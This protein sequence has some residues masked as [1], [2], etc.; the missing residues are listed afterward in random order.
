MLCIETGNNNKKKQQAEH[1]IVPLVLI[2][3]L[4]LLKKEM[5]DDVL[6]T[7]VPCDLPAKELNALNLSYKRISF[8]HWIVVHISR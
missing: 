6:D 8:I 5:Y 1:Q 3:R 2:V 4:I 7:M